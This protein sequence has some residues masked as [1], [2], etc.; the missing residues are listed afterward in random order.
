VAVWYGPNALVWVVELPGVIDDVLAAVKASEYGERYAADA[1]YVLSG[2]A[3]T[4]LS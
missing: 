1:I 4:K 2:L 3:K